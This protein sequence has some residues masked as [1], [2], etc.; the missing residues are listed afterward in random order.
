MLT[1]PINNDVK[2]VTNYHVRL[3]KK[4]SMKLTIT[5]R[6]ISYRIKTFEYF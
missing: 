2:T 3:Q 4:K 1:K 6:I 5:K